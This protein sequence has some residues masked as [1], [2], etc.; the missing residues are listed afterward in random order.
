MPRNK[1]GGKHHKHLKNKDTDESHHKNLVFKDELNKTDYACVLDVLGGGNMKVVC[2]SDRKE[3]LARI[4]GAMY[5]K[6]WIVKNDVV[7]VSLRDFQDSKCD[8]VLKYSKEEVESLL[9][10]KQINNTF[11][12]ID[13]DIEFIKDVEVEFI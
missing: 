2:Y 10:Y 8:I 7:L 4:R 11:L 12:N 5:K 1:I 3:R 9:E 13:V 6:V